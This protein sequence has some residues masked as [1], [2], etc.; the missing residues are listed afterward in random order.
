MTKVYQIWEVE[1]SYPY[2]RYT[3]ATGTLKQCSEAFADWLYQHNEDLD[4][5]DQAEWNEDHESVLLFC[6]N[7]EEWVKKY[8][9]DEIYSDWNLEYLCEV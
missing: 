5:E 7:P 6:N 1:E 3:L 4:E 8:G 2:E 9:D